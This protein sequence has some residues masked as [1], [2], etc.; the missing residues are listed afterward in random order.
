M[1]SSVLVTLQFSIHQYCPPW[2]CD[3]T[4]HDSQSTRQEKAASHMAVSSKRKEREA[5]W[6]GFPQDMPK[7]TR[8]HQT[9][10][11]V[12]PAP[13]VPQGWG[14]GAGG[15]WGPS[16]QHIGLGAEEQPSHSA[17]TTS[18]LPIAGLCLPPLWFQSSS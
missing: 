4:S 6:F 12:T 17:L 5:Q 16:L 11:N 8:F 18:T 3:Q 15:S 2:A 9:H 14:G 10:L 7:I 13:R 1:E